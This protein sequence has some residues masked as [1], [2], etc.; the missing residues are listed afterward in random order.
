MV[1]KIL[2]RFFRVKGEQVYVSYDGFA[3]VLLT[4]HARE[5]ML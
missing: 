5:F 2:L 1:R 4:S 3:K